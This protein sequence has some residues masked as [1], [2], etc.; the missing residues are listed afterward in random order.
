MATLLSIEEIMTGSAAAVEQVKSSAEETKKLRT[1][2][3]EASDR[4]AAIIDQASKDAEAVARQQGLAALAVQQENLK[5]ASAV[6]VTEA[7]NALLDLL[8]AQKQANDRLLTRTAKIRELRGAM[9]GKVGLASWIGRNFQAA[10]Q[11]KALEG[12]VKE[13]AA[14]STAITN[15]HRALQETFVTNKGKAEVLTAE[16][17]AAQARIAAAD[18][19]VRSEQAVIEGIGYNIQSL[20]EARN[21]TIEQLNVKYGAR[22]AVS[23]IKAEQRAEESQALERER[24]NWQKEEAKIRQDL[25]AAEKK[26]KQEAKQLS[27]DFV[28]TVNMGRATLKLP[29]L[30]AVQQRELLNQFKTGQVRKDIS[31]HYELGIKSRQNGGKQ[32]LGNSPAAAAALV[33]DPEL[34][35]QISAAQ[36]ET[37]NILAT[38][39]QAIPVQV[40]NSKD[41]AAINRSLNDN[42][43]QIVAEQFGTKEGVAGKGYIG[44]DSPFSVGDLGAPESG[45][46]SAPVLANMPLV[47]KVLQPLATAGTKLQDPKAVLEIAR[48]AIRKGEITSSQA[49]EGLSRV[50]QVANLMNQAQRNFAG[51]GIQL[52]NGGAQ[53]VVRVGGEKIDLT[54]PEHIQRILMTLQRYGGDIPPIV[55]KGP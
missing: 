48:A 10:F 15:T 16:T 27:E 28:A 51:Y 6:G 34:D 39:I 2:Q 17:I 25:L 43:K 18:A 45:Y 21:S 38:A 33:F 5:A 3:A 52:P 54:K 8:A 9:P 13:V 4:Q 55:F 41:K 7:S 47:T 49:A 30:D 50:Y 42:V 35:V 26:D 14:I 32:V 23:G 24:F 44:I 53:Y 36:E 22:Q 40:K 19:K 20:A 31:L 37:K 1:K 46:L 29:A 12:E 11:E